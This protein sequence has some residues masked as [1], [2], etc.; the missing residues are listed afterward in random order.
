MKKPTR[1]QIEEAIDE[2]GSAGVD[3]NEAVNKIE[4]AGEL[5]GIRCKCLIDA[6]QKAA[7]VLYGKL[8][9]LEEQH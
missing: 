7:C 8:H 1:E 2:L 4:R 6:I 5:S 3:L 9:R